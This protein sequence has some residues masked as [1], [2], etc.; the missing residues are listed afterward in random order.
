MLLSASVILN[1]SCLPEAGFPLYSDILLADLRPENDLR[2]GMF[3]LHREVTTIRDVILSLFSTKR[4]QRVEGKRTSCRQTPSKWP[5]ERARLVYR[6]RL[7]AIY[8]HVADYTTLSAVVNE[9]YVLSRRSTTWTSFL[10]LLPDF[11]PM[12][13]RTVRCGSYLHGCTSCADCWHSH[14][15][16]FLFFS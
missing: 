12:T 4:R 11:P 16:P 13:T 14:C 10:H 8:A 2:I 15:S 9:G 1:C 7:A 6:P 5:L 3:E